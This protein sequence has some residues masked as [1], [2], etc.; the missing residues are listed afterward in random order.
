MTCCGFVS[1]CVYPFCDEGEMEQCYQLQGRDWSRLKGGMEFG[2][3][4]SSS[5]TAAQ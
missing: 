2:L 1:S 4:M 5:C 3:M